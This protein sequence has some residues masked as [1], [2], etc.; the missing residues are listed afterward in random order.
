MKSHT[1]IKF[2]DI[3]YN[4]I[5]ISFNHIYDHNNIDFIIDLSNIIIHNIHH[6]LMSSY[7]ISTMQYVDLSNDTV[8]NVVVTSK[9]P[10]NIIQ[11][12]ENITEITRN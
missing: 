5:D 9:D 8:T 2:S 10:S 12:Y 1:K 11:I 7:N 6:I 4:H 3:N